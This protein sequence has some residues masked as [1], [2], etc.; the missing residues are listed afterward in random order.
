MQANE[1]VVCVLLPK[2]VYKGKMSL[3]LHPDLVLMI[4]LG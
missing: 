3:V 2:N 4:K 1:V